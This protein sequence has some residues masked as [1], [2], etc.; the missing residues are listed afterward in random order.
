MRYIYVEILK[1]YAK[2]YPPLYQLLNCNDKERINELRAFS[3]EY[4]TYLLRNE[5]LTCRMELSIRRA[6]RHLGY[7]PFFSIITA[8]YNPPIHFLK[9]ALESVLVQPYPFYEICIADD[10]SNGNIRHFLR[11]FAERHNKQVKLKLLDRHGG[12]SFALNNAIKMARGEFLVFLDHDDKISRF[13]L[14]E[15]ARYLNEHPDADLI[16]SDEDKINLKG[17]RDI[18]FFKPQWSPDT[19]LSAMY[20]CHL[21]VVRKSLVERL[22]GFISEYDGAQDYDLVLRVSEITQRIH[23]IPRVFYSWREWRGSS[24][25]SPNAKPYAFIAAKKAISDYLKRQG[26]S[27]FEVKDAPNAWLGIY[28]IER[29]VQDNEKCSIIIHPGDNCYECSKRLANS[30][31]KYCHE[32][33]LLTHKIPP[34]TLHP[35]VKVVSVPLDWG[36]TKC[37]NY[38]ASKAQSPY[39]LFLSPNIEPISKDWLKHL[40]EHVIRKEIG[41]CSGKILYHDGTIQHAGIILGIQGIR[42]YS[43]RCLPWDSPG[44]IGALSQIR[45]YSAVTIN[46]L[47]T[48]KGL[49]LSL[50]GF[51][52]RLEKY[53]DV[54][55]C[56]R[57]IEL[58]KRVVYTPYSIMEINIDIEPLETLYVPEEAGIIRQKWGKYIENDPYYNPN[59]SRY[60]EDFR[61]R[62]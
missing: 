7:K 53:A 1:K 38:G 3:P 23:R 54:D 29:R 33:M 9:S 8:C 59:L 10:G 56:L 25:A 34:N 52:E 22:G 21:L 50:G 6:S 26:E 27:G 24:S 16:Y 20:I 44:Y 42:G 28:W 17:L 62:L 41:A 60:L 43:H 11:K 4:E 14:F 32:I 12:I 47:M 45:N 37:L 13:A 49:F 51:D 5:L 40:M 61:L 31:L 55:Y 39:I 2:L 19:F 18:Y 58:G 15:I 36:I 48:K 46:A 30:D 35:K 57:L